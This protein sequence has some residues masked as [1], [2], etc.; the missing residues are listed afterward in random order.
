MKIRNLLWLVLTRLTL[1][2]LVISSCIGI[3]C[4]AFN[5]AGRSIQFPP[6]AIPVL[7]VPVILLGLTL[8][9]ST[10]QKR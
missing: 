2:A 10:V 6:Q 1:G 4:L 3:V 7:W 8:V 5:L 9:V